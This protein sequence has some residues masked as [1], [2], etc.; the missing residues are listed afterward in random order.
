M[1]A[2]RKGRRRGA[3]RSEPLRRPASYYVVGEL[4]LRAEM[5]RLCALEALGGPGGALARRPPALKVRRAARRPR[6]RLGF[7]VPEEHRLSVTVW[8]GARRGD[9]LETLLHELVHIA[10][11]AG[12]GSRRWHGRHFSETL[13]RAMKEAYGVTAARGPASRHGAWA[14]A[15]ERAVQPSSPSPPRPR[16][17]PAGRPPSAIPGA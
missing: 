17:R 16:P 15:I 2:R 12:P 14:E 10:A 7:A 6:S 8:P 9:L 13:G 1:W 3:R 5:L 4:D 11:G